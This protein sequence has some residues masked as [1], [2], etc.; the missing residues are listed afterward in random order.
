[1]QEVSGVNFGEFGGC[2]CSQTNSKEVIYAG[3]SL[4]VC[5]YGGILKYLYILKHSMTF[6]AFKAKTSYDCIQ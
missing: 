6:K 4:L 5:M 1:M 3:T 2:Y